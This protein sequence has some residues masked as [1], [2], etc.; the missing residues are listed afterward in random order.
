MID[1]I[2]ARVKGFFLE[3]V[4]TFRQ[5][6]NDEPRAVFTYF[7]ALLL[8]Y[9]V[10][11]SLVRAVFGTGGAV[12]IVAD[13]IMTVI[14]GFVGMLVFAAWVHLWVYVVGGREGIMQTV[15]ALFYGSTPGLLLGWIP[16][17][18]IIFSL[19]SLVLYVLGIRDLQG[20]STA[21]AVIGVAIAVVIPL[22][23]IALLAAYF[24]V[25]VVSV[26]TPVPM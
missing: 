9:A 11:S 16:F 7:G 12:G 15:N 8:F 23:L 13:L 4:E 6:K 20:I 10:I 5:S 21:R 3:P 26:T 24:M 18:G 1:T 25:S 2:V 17:V 22:V 19:W 14:G